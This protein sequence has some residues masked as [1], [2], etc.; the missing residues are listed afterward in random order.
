MQ[1]D[2]LRAPPKNKEWGWRARTMSELF[3]VLKKTREG[4][5][6]ISAQLSLLRKT[7]AFGI[8]IVREF[9]DVETATI[10]DS[11]TSDSSY[12]LLDSRI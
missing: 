8:R 9:V 6:S 1:F 7:A 2:L 5:L 10:S 12:T 11:P 3:C 4:M